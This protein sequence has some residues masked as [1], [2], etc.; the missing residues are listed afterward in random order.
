A[1]F[2]VAALDVDG[3]AMDP[4]LASRILR[5]R[6]MQRSTTNRAWFEI[7]DRIGELRLTDGTIRA[8][9][10]PRGERRMAHTARY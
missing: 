10:W 2:R 5:S 7:P 8:L 9:P 6:T 1:A 3:R 4:Q